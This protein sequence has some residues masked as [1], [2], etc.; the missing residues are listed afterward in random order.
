MDQAFRDA[1]PLSRARR[2]KGVRDPERTRAAILSAAVHEFTKKG[3]GGA[4][5]NEIA[6]LSGANKRMIY[7]YFGDKEVLYLAAL[8]SVYAAIRS[9]EAELHLAEREPVEAMRELTRFTWRYFLAHPE[10]LSLLATENLLRARHLK[11]STRIL[12][13]HSPLLATLSTVLQKGAAE[14]RF[15][16]G[17]DPVWLY[18]TIASL[19][20]FYLSN[21]Y[22]LSA[23]FR[24][25]LAAPAALQ[26][27][28]AHIV[29]VV[30]AYLRPPG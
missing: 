4:R 1:P 5:I 3:Y 22:T 23:I 9:A 24:R 14:G 21:R 19:G 13:M 16:S 12:E 25:E 15:R 20:F 29:E 11:R 26:A 10:F 28:G 7:H 6:K 30:L 27:W 18:I 17:V 8:E 2:T